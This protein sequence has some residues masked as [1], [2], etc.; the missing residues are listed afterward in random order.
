MA[1]ERSRPTV[2]GV[3][4]VPRAQYFFR[5][6]TGVSLLPP[7]RRCTADAGSC[8]DHYSDRD[9]TRYRQSGCERRL[10]SRG[11]LT[12]RQA[13]ARWRGQRPF[14]GAM[15]LFASAGFLLLPAFVTIR[16]GDVLISISTI[17]GVSTLLLAALM[18]SCA[19]SAMLRV[20]LRLPVGVC[21]MVLALVTLPAAN[22]GGLVIGTFAGVAG[23]AYVLAWAPEDVGSVKHRCAI[24]DVEIN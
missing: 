11:V 23:S 18:A 15:L 24:E 1:P 12:R 16:V 6:R 5:R 21:A 10:R 3:E 17:A 2:E 22:F 7:A 19:F 8:R 9:T 20:G 13:F 4:S 14:V